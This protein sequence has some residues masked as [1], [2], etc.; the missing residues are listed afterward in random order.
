MCT[1]CLLFCRFTNLRIYLFTRLLTIVFVVGISFN[2]FLV[3]RARR[4]DLRLVGG[5]AA[6]QRH[7]LDDDSD[8]HLFDQSV[9]LN[10]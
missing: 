9:A 3:C 1:C 10:G 2:Y 5:L 4:V 6:V 8:V 7:A